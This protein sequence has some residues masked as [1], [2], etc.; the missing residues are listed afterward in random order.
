MRHGVAFTDTRKARTSPW[1]GGSA[2]GAYY[3]QAATKPEAFLNWNPRWA[4]AYEDSWIA[5]SQNNIQ[6][7]TAEEAQRFQ[8][9]AENWRRERGITS[10][11][12]KMVLCPSYQRIIATMGERAVPFI[13][14]ELEQ[15]RDDPDH[16]FWA[17]EMITEADPVP[18]D[19]Y[20]DTVRM[21]EAWLVWAQGKYAW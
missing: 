16:W 18:V 15:T 17:L 13:L 1:I 9:L 11:V 14:R 20:G 7:S 12:T 19:A 10:S 8:T 6:V 3:H 2:S 5:R 21:A 4:L